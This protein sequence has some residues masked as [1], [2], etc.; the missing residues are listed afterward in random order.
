MRSG[1]A[2]HLIA[3]F[4]VSAVSQYAGASLAVRAFAAMPAAGVAWIR[5]LTGA[6]VLGAWRRPWRALRGQPRSALLLVAAFGV[7]LAD[8]KSTRLNSSHLTQSR[9]PSSA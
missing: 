7:A 6:A 2:P 1:T 4:V 5:V 8:R 9:M 3:L